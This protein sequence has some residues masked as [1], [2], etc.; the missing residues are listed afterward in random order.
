MTHWAIIIF[1]IIFFLLWRGRG[2]MQRGALSF[3]KSRAREVSNESVTFDDVAGVDEAVDEL[4]EVVDFLKRPDRYAALGARIPKGVLLVGPPGTGKTLLARAVA[5]EAAVP[6]FQMSG[7]DFVEMFVGVGAAR[8]RDTFKKAR[9]QAPCIIFIDEL[10]ALGRAR[11]SGALSHEEREQT[12]NQLLVEMDGFDPSTGIIVMAATNRPE[13]LDG[14]LL[15]AG[16]FDRQVSVDRPSKEGRLAILQ[17]HIRDVAMAEDVD[18]QRVAARTAGLAGADLANLVNE[19]ALLTARKQKT[20]VTAVEFDEAIERAAMG[21]EKK[22]RL[23]SEEEK[24]IVAY[25]ELGHAVVAEVLPHAESVNK[26]TIVP[27]GTALGVT[28]SQPAEDRYVVMRSFLIDSIAVLL[29]GRAAELLFVGEPGAGS[30]NDLARATSIASDM[31]RR[32]GMSELGSRTFERERAAMV[33]SEFALASP[34]EHGEQMADS[35]DK[36]INGIVEEGLRRAK[37]VLEDHR[38]PIEKLA[39]RLIE[40]QQL[41]GAEVREALGLPPQKQATASNE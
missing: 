6:F 15:R 18:L 37:K 12:L 14:A 34:R 28:W 2:G 8:V 24:R 32:F 13:I 35:I 36:E 39:E 19:A 25:H 3:G 21:L 9:E 41:S 20:S 5:G 10:D 7:S 23:L 1:A 22:G 4:R 11:G 16:R 40:T 33:N 29:G 26:V 38:P 17:I 27:R 31:V 30:S